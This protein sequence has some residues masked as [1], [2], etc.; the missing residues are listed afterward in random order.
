L[1]VSLEESSVSLHNQLKIDLSSQRFAEQYEEAAR[2]VD[3]D[4]F[5]DEYRVSELFDTSVV[6]NYAHTEHNN[7]ICNT[8]MDD[9]E[10]LLIE[11]YDNYH[12]DRDSKFIESS[13]YHSSIDCTSPFSFIDTKTSVKTMNSTQLKKDFAPIQ[14]SLIFDTNDDNNG[15]TGEPFQVH[16]WKDNSITVNPLHGTMVT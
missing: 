4:L 13:P 5:Y 2:C 11:E 12:T 15:Y 14:R 9:S 1:L 8:A 10:T 7:T 16:G 6:S 3:G